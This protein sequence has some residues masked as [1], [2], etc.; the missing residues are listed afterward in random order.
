[1]DLTRRQLMKY[2][3]GAGLSLTLP[4]H[5][6]TRLAVAAPPASSRLAG[7]DI[8]KYELPLVIPPAMPRTAKIKMPGNRQADYFEI[9]VREF[10]QQ[11][12]PAQT[13]LGP[14]K[15]WSYCSKLAPLP[16]PQGGTLHYPALTIE[17]KFNAPTR[18]KWIN[19]LMDAKGDYLPHLL[20][21]DQTLH[22]ANPP[23]GARGRDSHGRKQAPY[24]GPVPIVT[25]VHGAVGVAEAKASAREGD[26]VAV[27]GVIGGRRDALSKDAGVF[28]M[29]DAS[30]PSCADEEGDNGEV[31]AGLVLGDRL[32]V[33]LDMLRAA[34]R[35]G[36]GQLF[37][38]DWDHAL[39]MDP[40]EWIS[41][42]I[43]DIPQQKISKIDLTSP[44]GD[45]IDLGSRAPG[46]HRLERRGIVLGVATL[47]VFR[48]GA[49]QADILGRDLEC[50]HLAILQCRDLGDTGRR[51]LVK[52]VAVHDPDR[53]RTQTLE[54]MGQR[55]HPL[56]REDS[57]E[58]ARDA[59]RVGKR[60]EQVEDG[61]GTQFDARRADVAHG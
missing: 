31:L 12:L 29:M 13:G 43:V 33:G 54:H 30:I 32:S 14:T 36:E 6:G 51:H 23:G 24:R 35:A 26:R 8:P 46:Q 16:V 17:S 42:D 18:V 41:T 56:W 7:A 2:G 57:D 38:T 15:V 58:L 4:W 48:P 52:A 40:M 27:R 47:E 37:L 10:T 55:F 61:A 5:V 28:V 39:S 20:P 19:E 45:R 25:H 3:A 22:W 60:S 1:M 11:I 53:F 21:V 9:A 59:G 44:Q 50:P 34:R 49:R